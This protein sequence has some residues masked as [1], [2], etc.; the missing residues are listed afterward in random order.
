[1]SFRWTSPV[2]LPEDYAVTESPIVVTIDPLYARH[3]VA[4]R[5]RELAEGFEQETNTPPLSTDAINEFGYMSGHWPRMKGKPSAS[6]RP[7][8]NA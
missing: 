2:D 4:R 3:E 1:M 7:P 5:L 8:D 6:P